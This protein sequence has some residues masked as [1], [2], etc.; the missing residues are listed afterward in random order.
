M[1]NLLI[2]DDNSSLREGIGSYFRQ[3]GHLPILAC[4]VHEAVESIRRQAPDVILSDFVMGDGTGMALRQEV[5]KLGLRKDPYFI[6][7]TGHP[8]ADN[9]NEAYNGGVDLYL[10]KPFQMPALALAVDGGLNRRRVVS[11]ADPVLGP[12]ESFYHDFFLALN[13]VLPRLLMLMEGRYG[14]LGP[15]QVA[16]ISSIFDIWRGVV[17]TMADF[18]QR[19]EDPSSGTIERRR[20]SGPAA[21]RRILDKL[22][23]DLTV[24]QLQ[25][26]VVREPRL[27]LG[28]V[29]EP[30]AEAL[31]EAL[32][33]R[34][35]AFSAPGATLFLSWTTSRERLLFNLR[36]D[37]M[38]PDLNV[39]L[40]RNVALLPPVLPMLE[41]AGVRVIVSDT[42]GPWTLSFERPQK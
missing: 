25:I 5:R 27:P 14:G 1:A 31:V 36:S 21:L 33:L 32:I 11:A 24:A 22:Q 8:T 15:E 12:A 9:A 29:H 28:M 34:M 26:D 41:E 4:G 2:V 6:L 7:M 19:L 39:E 18:Y 42:V 20:W 30:T 35:A 40:M 17:W 10:T 16:S 23:P 3:Q 13:P 37:A 38:H